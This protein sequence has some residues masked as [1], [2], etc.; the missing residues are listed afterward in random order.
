MVLVTGSWRMYLVGLAASLV[1]FA[2]LFFTVI[3]PSQNTAN[4]A[5]KS[6]L[7]QTQQAL[8]QAQKE[9]T[10]ASGQTSSGGGQV[11]QQAQQTLTRAQKLTSCLAN[12]GIDPTKAQACETQYGQ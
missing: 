8:S 4:Q 9:F 1:V 5:V 7:Q 12:A 11:Q 10:P 2:V 3:Q 6:G